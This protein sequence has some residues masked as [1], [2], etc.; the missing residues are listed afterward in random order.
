MKTNTSSANL[1][2]CIRL[3]QTEQTIKAK[4]AYEVFK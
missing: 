3:G 1:C 2:A 4:P